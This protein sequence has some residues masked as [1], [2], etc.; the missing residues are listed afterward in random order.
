MSE[1]PGKLDH[2]TVVAYNVGQWPNVA[3]SA[4]TSPCL[5]RRTLLTD[6]SLRT[7]SGLSAGSGERTP[8]LDRHTNGDEYRASPASTP[9]T[10]VRHTP[11]DDE[12][13]VSLADGD[14]TETNDDSSLACIPSLVED[15]TACDANMTLTSSMAFAS[16]VV[17]DCNAVVVESYDIDGS[18][19]SPPD[20]LLMSESTQCVKMIDE[21]SPTSMC[22]S[23][24]VEVS[25]H[26]DGI[27]MHISYIYS[28]HFVVRSKVNRLRRRC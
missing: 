1:M 22:R 27:Q 17:K 8:R 11:C 4:P 25:P 24:Q 26:P 19:F 5:E 7:N 18:A 6:A 14:E 20:Y 16:I 12:R 23:V 28:N 9:S 13:G 3:A 15:G 10:P 2:A 21:L